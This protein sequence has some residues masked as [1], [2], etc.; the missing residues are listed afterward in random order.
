MSNAHVRL[1]TVGNQRFATWHTPGATPTVVF[2]TGLGAESVEWTAVAQGLASRNATFFYDRLNR[3]GSD[4]V[5]G[6]RTSREMA[7]DLR[8]VLTAAEVAPPYVLVGHSFGAHVVLAF[9]DGATDVC[10]VVLVEPT[11]PRQF[12]TLGP[13]LPEG[14]MRD[15]WTAGWRATDST[16]EHIDFPASFMETAGVSLGTVPMVVLAAGAVMPGAG[17]KPQRMWEAMA[18]DWLSVSQR[19]TL[20]VVADAG[21]FIQRE[22]PDRVIEGIKTVLTLQR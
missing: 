6:P 22:R 2:E 15:F 13:F 20:H 1:T 10:G 3:G 4:S 8:A 5:A 16:A 11:H 18:R 9:A 17:P 19:A 21:H 12:D 14:D 7:D